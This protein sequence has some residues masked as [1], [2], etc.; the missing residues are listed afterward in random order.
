MSYN[1]VIIVVLRITSQSPC[2]CSC[3]SER[4][5]W[6]N[7]ST[8]GLEVPFASTVIP[9][10][11]KSEIMNEVPMVEAVAPGSKLCSR[12]RSQRRWRKSEMLDD[13][14]NWLDEPLPSRT[15]VQIAAAY[16]YQ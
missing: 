14:Y 5:T 16:F 1:V 4:L 6:L 10:L 2:P 15:L 7:P 9:S 12:V 11:T 13:T 3:K 8:Y